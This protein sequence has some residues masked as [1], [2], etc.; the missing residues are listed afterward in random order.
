MKPFSDLSIIG[1]VD[2]EA[3]IATYMY[4]NMLFLKNENT[5]RFLVEDVKLRHF[6]AKVK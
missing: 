6:G 5:R 1:F 3:L 4:N 2:E